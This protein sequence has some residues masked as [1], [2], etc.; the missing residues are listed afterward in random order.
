ATVEFVFAPGERD[1]YSCERTPNVLAPLGAKPGGG[2]L[3]AAGKGDCTPM[4]LRIK[5]NRQAINISPLWGE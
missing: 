5:K 1:V 2:T 4:E 3:T